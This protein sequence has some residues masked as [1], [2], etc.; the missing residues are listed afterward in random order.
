MYKFWNMLEKDLQNLI[1]EYCGYKNILCFRTNAG[2]YYNESETGKKYKIKGMSKG[3]PDLIILINSKTL[4]VE[5]KKLGGKQSKD[6][7]KMEIDINE[8]GNNYYLIDNF[9]DF[10][11]LIKKND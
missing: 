10:E 7:K 1:I 3:F 8:T 2:D 11:K 9:E 5:L 4:F 6:Q